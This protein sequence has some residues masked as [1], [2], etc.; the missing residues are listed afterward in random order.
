ME[1]AEVRENL[2]NIYDSKIEKNNPDGQNR[3]QRELLLKMDFDVQEL[4]VRLTNRFLE[5]GTGCSLSISLRRSS[6]ITMAHQA[7]KWLKS[8]SY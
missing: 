7:S 1:T 4:T 5:S 6:P 2:L 3:Y 8:N